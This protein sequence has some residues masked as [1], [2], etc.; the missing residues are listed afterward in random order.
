MW[1]I[2]LVVAG[3]E[4][5]SDEVES[6]VGGTQFEIKV[7]SCIDDA[8][9]RIRRGRIDILVIDEALAVP[10]LVVPDAGNDPDV[11]RIVLTDA[12]SSLQFNND[13]RLMQKPYASETLRGVLKDAMQ[14]SVVTFA[15]RLHLH[16]RSGAHPE[17]K[18]STLLTPEERDSES[19]FVLSPREG[20]VLELLK[21][22]YGT[23]HIARR[24]S[25]SVFTV[26]NHVKAI[27][28]KVGIH[29]RGDLRGQRTPR[30]RVAVG[31]ASAGGNAPSS[32]P[33]KRGLKNAC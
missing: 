14:Q 4:C 31:A 2:I 20:E 27:Y 13:I 6:I 18:T 12:P 24:L 25:I 7:A 21:L 30:N 19:P 9:I 11:V 23:S 3:E 1:G 15:A 32:I 17:S 28:R 29:S 22:G 10:A 8:L 33:L 26:R 16:L 5:V